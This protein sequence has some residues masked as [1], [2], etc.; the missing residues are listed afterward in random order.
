MSPVQK[1][2]KH[3]MPNIERFT[4]TIRNGNRTRALS[5]R[6]IGFLVVDDRGGRTMATISTSG[7]T[8]NRQG[9]TT[10]RIILNGRFTNVGGLTKAGWKQ[11][12][13]TKVINRTG[14]MLRKHFTVLAQR[15]R[16]PRVLTTN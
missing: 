2:D 8:R 5:S 12:I 16:E 14:G 15:S 13:L 11:G 4:K 6:T 7:Y 10:T 3:K 9:T 1:Y